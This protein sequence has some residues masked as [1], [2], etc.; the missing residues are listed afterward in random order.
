M[1]TSEQS[2]ALERKRKITFQVLIK[3]RGLKREKR[4]REKKERK[5]KM[6]RRKF[7]L[8]EHVEYGYRLLYI[9]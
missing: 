4:E 7:S 5:R 9:A 2:F 6:E 3:S 8:I 1:Q